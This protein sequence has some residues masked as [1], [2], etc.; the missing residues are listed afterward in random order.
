MAEILVT[1]ATGLV[2]HNIARVLREQGKA[3]RV[4]A[5]DPQ[6][7]AGIVPEGCEIVGGDVTVPATLRA[8]CA[9]I[10]TVYHAAG[11]PEQWLPDIDTFRRVNVEGT[12]NMI[13]AANE[14]GVRRFVYT[15]TIDVFQAATG[16]EY[17]ER[18]I[19]PA[20]KGTAYERSK[21]AADHLVA[22]AVAA[23]MDA[24]FLHP[25]GVYGPGPAPSPGLNTFIVDLNHGKIP[26]LLP[27]GFPVVY[28]HDVALGHIA[29]AEHAETG[30]RYILSECY[31]SL[32]ETA[33]MAAEALGRGGVPPVMPLW[34]GRVV[35]H[36][37]EAVSR[38]IGRAPLIP[39]GQLHFMQWQ[40]RPSSAK[41]QRELGWRPTPFAEGVALTVAWLRDQ[42]RL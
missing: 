21:Q 28:A 35:A 37:G 13:A 38:V 5:R 15:S 19:D 39:K 18:V 9:G 34:L 33:A 40:A 25:S 24:V 36:A 14:C 26:M 16:A 22:A 31:Y 20:P 12:R 6:R 29:A 17:D 11:L 2:G 3:V 23:G 7:A 4:L 42:G 10:D 27:G 41:A 32:Q 8:A 1:G 30:A